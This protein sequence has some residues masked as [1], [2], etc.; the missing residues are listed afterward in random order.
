MAIAQGV[1]KQTRFKRQGAKG[2][3]AGT[4]AGQ[5][6]R[7]QTATFELQRDTF[8]SADE[9]T[10]TQQLIS[11]RLGAK[12]INGQINGLLT[13]GTYS[14]LLS[15]LLRRDFTAVTAVTGASITIAAAGGGY[16][17]T[18]GTNTF[19]TKGIKVGMVVR[20]TAGA[21]NAAN[22]NKNIFVTNV[23]QTVI[24][25]VVVNGSA[26]VAEG[27]IASATVTVPGKVT[28][29]PGAGQTTVYYTFEEWFP[30]VPLSERFQDCRIGQAQ[31]TLPGQGNATIQMQV[32]GLDYSSNVAAYF[33]SPTV[34]T[35][36]EVCAAST[37]AML[38]QG[39]VV[40]VLTDLQFTINGNQTPADPVVGSVLRP[41]VFVGKVMV[42]GQFTAYFD[43]STNTDLF[44]QE[45]DVAIA[46]VLP[47]TSQAAADF[48]S[49]SMPKLNLTSA[50][51]QD[52]ETGLKRTYKFMAE[53]YAAGGAAIKDQQ[54]TLQIQD[55]QA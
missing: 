15:A 3:L 46:G 22:L 36:T 9:I 32:Q 17:L 10:S 37:G 20:L 13:P 39:V 2:A 54:T 38:V 55:S 25:G 48:I 35:S 11:Q 44:A 23:T 29:T 26:M 4:S 31:L 51:P 42:D 7:R 47:S 8:N 5:I 33:T 41:D 43:S 52:G 50:T 19:L 16:T 45:T 18:D 27:P 28:Y 34:E 30:D 1:A 40:A 14:D 24:T 49:Y 21:F 12:L 53:Y 6:L